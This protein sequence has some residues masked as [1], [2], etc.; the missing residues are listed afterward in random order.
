MDVNTTGGFSI[1]VSSDDKERPRFDFGADILNDGN[2][3]IKLKPKKKK[4][5]KAKKQLKHQLSNIPEE[6]GNSPKKTE[7]LSEFP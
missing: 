6:E 7:G 3:E 4:K 5:K 1:K 2:D